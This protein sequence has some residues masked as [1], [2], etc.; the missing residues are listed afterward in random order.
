MK[1]LD[2]YSVSIGVL[3]AIDTFLT[4]TVLPIP[5]WVTF[6]AWASFFILGGKKSGLIQSIASNLTGIAIASLTLLAISI[7]GGSPLIAAI[8]VGL[9]SA[10]MVQ[11]SKVPILTAIPAI[12]WGFASTVGTTVATGKPIT[13]PGIDNPAIVAAAAMIIGGLFGYLSELWGDAMTKPSV[14][15]REQTRV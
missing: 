12:V 5:V 9:G 11:A 15:E 7:I 1:K 13:T 8:C 2:A 3:G 6:I 10:A 14:V 4:A